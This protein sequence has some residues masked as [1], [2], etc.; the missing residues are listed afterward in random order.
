MTRA[1]YIVNK[2]KI[3]SQERALFEKQIHK[4]K[5]IDHFA[6]PKIYELFKND[7]RFF[8]VIE[9]RQGESL[10]SVLERQHYFDEAAAAGIMW[11][12]LG[13][14]NHCHSRGIIHTDLK[15]TSIIFNS[16]RQESI[17]V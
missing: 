10:A 17:R 6:I 11:Q 14:L 16:K 12:L 9:Y 1:V 8:V 13:L 15:L 7:H 5:R 2:Y 3:R 4:L